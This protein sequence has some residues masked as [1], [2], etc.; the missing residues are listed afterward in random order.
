MKRILTF[1]VAV[2]MLLLSSC[3]D[4]KLESTLNESAI[5]STAQQFELLK[6][7]YFPNSYF[8]ISVIP[9]KE[10]YSK[11]GDGGEYSKICTL[12]ENALPSFEFIDLSKSLS[13]PSYYS[14]D[15][16]WRQEK[17]DGVLSALGNV[18]SFEFNIDSFEANEFSPFYGYNSRSGQSDE[19]ESLYYLTSEITGSAKVY[20][21]D[22]MNGGFAEAGMYDLLQL[23]S[24]DAYNVFLSGAQ[25]LIKIENPHNKSG[26]SIAIFRD[27]YASSLSPLMSEFYSEIYLIDLRYIAI[28]LLEDYI[29]IDGMDI[30]LLYGVQVLKSGGILK[31]W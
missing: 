27:S 24:D 7:K 16:H 29:D 22:T 28:P 4:K 26:K 17:L 5:I 9:A 21:L 23:E 3:G 1:C 15:P 12:M 19:F 31:I 8:Y 25:P 30:L 14:T 20:V 10:Y 11:E 18:F 2:M 13:G 6:E